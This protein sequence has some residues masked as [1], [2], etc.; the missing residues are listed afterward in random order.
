MPFSIYNWNCCCH[1]KG[2]FFSLY[3]HM[4][5]VFICTYV[6]TVSWSFFLSFDRITTESKHFNGHIS[7]IHKFLFFAIKANNVENNMKK[8]SQKMN[9]WC[10]QNIWSWILT[11]S[12][13]HKICA[14]KLWSNQ[15]NGRNQQKILKR[16]KNWAIFFCSHALSSMLGWQFF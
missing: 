9:S 4:Q 7:S 12:H 1:L 11:H 6:C 2:L 3:R 10:L 13:L 8:R 16:N 5:L 14:Y 15:E